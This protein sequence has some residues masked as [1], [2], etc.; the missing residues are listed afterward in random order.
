MSVHV[1]G[2]RS[3]KHRIYTHIYMRDRLHHLTHNIR[4]VKYH[5]LDHVSCVFVTYDVSLDVVYMFIDYGTHDLL[6]MC[7]MCYISVMSSAVSLWVLLE[8]GGLF[9]ALWAVWAL[10]GFPG[11]LLAKLSFLGLA[12]FGRLRLFFS[13]LGGLMAV[14]GLVF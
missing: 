2:F 10:L 8:L 9:W 4:S 6:G 1:F 12:E 5:V 14:G 3:S 11:L 7:V 13:I